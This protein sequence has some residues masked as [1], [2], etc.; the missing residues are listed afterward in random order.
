M[1]VDL[2][3][4]LVI[5]ISSRALFDL[6]KENKIF[7]DKGSDAYTK[8]QIEHENE[9]LTPGTGFPL[10][11]AILEL[12]KIAPDKRKAEVVIISRNNADAG[13]RVLNSIR[14]FHLDMTRAS[15]TSG[16]PV[17]KYLQALNVSLFL[18]ADEEDVRM[19]LHSKVPAALIY[20]APKDVHAPIGEI[21]IAFDGDA[22]IFSDES[23]MIYQSQGIETFMNHEK[24]NA[25]NPLPE[26]PFAK[27]LRALAF[28]QASAQKDSKS[29][30]NIKTA[31]V[32]ARNAP[33]DE[34][35]I[36]TLRYWKVRVDSMF[37]LGGVSK[38]KILQAFE[39]HIFFDDQDA[40]CLPA[41]KLVPTARV[42]R[43]DEEVVAQQNSFANLKARKEGKVFRIDQSKKTREI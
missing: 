5:G 38:D 37:F 14:H 1:P 23:E 27:F 42:P 15:F 36:R 8:Y 6:E 16:E 40:H 28:L 9:I 34:R 19:A 24:L 18:S 30:I 17:S 13:L 2:S 7:Q 20:T 21:R 4:Y 11:K 29:S 41:S 31:I 25:R 3:N 12:N 33:A 39:P 32:T 26:G 43:F 10:V 22:V 35:V